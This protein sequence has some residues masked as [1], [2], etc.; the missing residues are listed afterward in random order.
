MTRDDDLFCGPV[1]LPEKYGQKAYL[2]VYSCG[3]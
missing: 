2:T 3:D 1:S